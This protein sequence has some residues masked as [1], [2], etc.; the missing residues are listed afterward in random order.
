MLHSHR[1][2]Q[3]S[4]LHCLPSAEALYGLRQGALPVAPVPKAGTRALRHL[5]GLSVSAAEIGYM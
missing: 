5:P 1:A 3:Q 2:T 4:R